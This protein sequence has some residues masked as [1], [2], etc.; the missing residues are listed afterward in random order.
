[1]VVCNPAG[2]EI[3]LIDI[4]NPAGAIDD[5]IGL[6]SMLTVVAGEGHSQPSIDAFDPPNGN[7]GPE[8][9]PDPLTFG[10]Q[11]SHG[12]DV[13]SGQQLRQGLED[14]HLDAGAGIDMP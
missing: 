10:S 5:A 4:G 11:A 6:G 7:A 13:H 1:M 14:S 2:G 12:I 8:T 9:D 3:K